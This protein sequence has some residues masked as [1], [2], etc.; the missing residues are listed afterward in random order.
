MSYD[1]VFCS[2]MC[3]LDNTSGAAICMRTYLTVLS[4]AG[5]RCA[6]FS[7]SLFDPKEEVPI[8]VLGVKVD[9]QKLLHKLAVIDHRNIKH[10]VLIT[11]SSQSVNMTREEKVR[12]QSA[13][14]GWLERYKPKIILTFGGSRFSAALHQMA[15][16][17]GAALVHYLANGEFSQ[18]DFV[19]PGDR[20]ICP[21]RFLADWYGGNPGIVADVLYP[22]IDEGRFSQ[23]E[24]NEDMLE[25]RRQL[26][27]ITFMNPIP[28]KGLALIY[29]LA[30]MA[31][32]HQLPYQFLVTEGRVDREWL[33]NSRYNLYRLPNV[34]MVPNRADVKEIYRR[35]SLLLVPSFWQEGFGRNIVE[36]QLAGVP[37]VASAIGGTVEALNGGGHAIAQDPMLQSDFLL[38]PTD[39]KLSQWWHALN[40]VLG[41]R[42]VYRCEVA[43]ALEAAQRFAPEVT[44]SAVVSYFRRQ[45]ATVRG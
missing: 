18:L 27:F 26:G 6:S 20:V 1:V 8:S 16:Q 7:A 24:C 38:P 35:T 11:E 22:I 9:K 23:G 5:L 14:G 39:Q 41:S 2:P 44:T 15:R 36:A 21:S 28:S 4:E 3:L 37:V 32:A 29:K 25:S 40:Y 34:W 10:H 45:L 30:E 33:R 43:K 31:M 17:Q 42:D 13:W 19:L 12:F